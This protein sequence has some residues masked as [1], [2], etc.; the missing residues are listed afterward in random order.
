MS[1]LTHFNET[2]AAHMVD[3]GSKAAT[4][5]VAITEGYIEMR[6]ETLALIMEG[7]HRK[8]DVLGIA[9]IAGIMASKRTADLIPLCHPI[10]ITHVDVKLEA[11]PERSRVR[12]EV[13]VKTVGA[14]GVEMEALTA[15]QIALLTIYDMCKSVDRGMTIRSVRLLE[16]AGGKSGHW[17]RTEADQ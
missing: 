4:E 2:G 14:T 13:T 7:G 9:R 11:E 3:V 15:T 17:R 12:C 5:R 8:G 6:P 16:K 1:K 10:P